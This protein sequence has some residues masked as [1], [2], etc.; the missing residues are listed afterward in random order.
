MTSK[1][2]EKKVNSKTIGNMPAWSH[3]RFWSLLKNKAKE[4]PNFRVIICHKDYATNTCSECR[5]LGRR[6]GGSE[7]FKCLP[8]NQQSD[9][10]L[11]AATDNL[12]KIM[13][14]IKKNMSLIFRD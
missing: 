2:Q 7:K 6:V 4:L 12:S 8:S 9:R 1:R 14:L 13:N 3:Y 10:D 5:F 11:N